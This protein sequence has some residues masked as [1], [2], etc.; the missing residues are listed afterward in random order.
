MSH[1][2]SLG[3]ISSK[4]ATGRPY[5]ET[6]TRYS[7]DD[8]EEQKNKVAGVF[9]FIILELILNIIEKFEKFRRP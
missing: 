1:M 5:F 3:T 7:G 4:G 6:Y 2:A 8:V 9:S